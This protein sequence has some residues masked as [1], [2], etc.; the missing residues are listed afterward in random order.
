M[1]TYERIEKWNKDRNNLEFNPELEFEMLMEELTEIFKAPSL[2]E[3]IQELCDLSFVGAGTEAKMKEPDLFLVCLHHGLTE[4]RDIY[5]EA[6]GVPAEVA[7]ECFDAVISANEKKGTTKDTNGKIIKGDA[8]T[9]P[10]PE[11]ISILEK[12]GLI[13]P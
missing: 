12:E 9:S 2:A 13:E 10:L 1:D 7:N 4:F 5:T 8:Y 6:L 11:I 3:K